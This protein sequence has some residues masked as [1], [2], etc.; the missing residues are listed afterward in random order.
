MGFGGGPIDCN[1]GGDIDG[2]ARYK[3]NRIKRWAR[4]GLPLY[5]DID[6]GFD[7]RRVLPSLGSGALWGDTGHVFDQWRNI[8]SELKGHQGVSNPS[9]AGLIVNS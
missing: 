4:S 2:L 6:V 9:I 1:K 3:K 8:D 5:A 7:N